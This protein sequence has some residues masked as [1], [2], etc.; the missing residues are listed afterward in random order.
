M[1]AQRGMYESALRSYMRDTGMSYHSA[2]T[3]PYFKDA[4]SQLRSHLNDRDRSRH[5]ALAEAMVE[6]GMRDEDDWWDVGDTPDF[7]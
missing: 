6:L 2:R 1:A 4:Y 7:T 3:D 5:S